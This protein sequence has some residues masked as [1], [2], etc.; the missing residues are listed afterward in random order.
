MYVMMSKDNSE[1][2]MKENRKKVLDLCKEV[3]ESKETKY[4]P[5]ALFLI[6]HINMILENYEESEKA[7]KELPKTIDPVTLYPLIYIKQGKNKEAKKLCDN[8]LLYY[9][10]NSCLMLTTLSNI[11]KTEQNYEKAFFY[12]D[13]CNKLQNLFKMGELSLVACKY[14]QLYIEIGNKDAAAKWFK[15]YIDRIVSA[16]YDYSNNLYFEGVELEIKTEEQRIIRKKLLQS[17]TDQEEFKS[18]A[19]IYDYEEAI[20]GLKEAILKCK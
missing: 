3:V 13:A 8:K 2:F 18:L 7:L 20:R 11:S 1:E 9:L 10:N 16:E 17:I 5:T 12:L 14:V 19:G 6:A 4:I 15:T